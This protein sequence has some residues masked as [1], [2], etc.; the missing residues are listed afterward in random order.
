MEKITAQ[1]AL[2]RL[3]ERYKEKVARGE[4]KKLTRLDIND[5]SGILKPG[6]E[7]IVLE[8]FQEGE[9]LAGT[10]MNHSEEIL[11]QAKGA[12]DIIV[13]LIAAESHTLMMDDMNELSIFVNMLNDNVNFYWNIDYE[14]TTAFKVKIEVY[15]VKKDMEVPEIMT[16]TRKYVALMSKI[17]LDER[18]IVDYLD[19]GVMLV[20]KPDCDQDKTRYL[21]NAGSQRAY[22]IS[23]HEG[24]LQFVTKDDIDYDSIKGL[25]NIDDAYKLR[26]VREFKIGLF[27]ADIALVKWQLYEDGYTVDE[28]TF[29]THYINETAI[30]AYIDE[31]LHLL[32]KFEDLSGP[33]LRRQR[34]K[35]ARRVFQQKW[36]HW[37]PFG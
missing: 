2:Y 14:E 26:A 8:C 18:C 12:S 9:T 37:S 6:T 19:E 23:D 21:I 29:E 4:R 30:Y 10:L 16:E 17:F 24:N 34:A 27:N 15:I 13:Q 28:D 25:P 36:K 11:E 22:P 32:T 20:H 3:T 31:N 1:E 35:E 7:V 5:Y 33:T